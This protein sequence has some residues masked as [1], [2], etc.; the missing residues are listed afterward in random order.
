MKLGIALRRN[1]I[2]GKKEVSP[3]YLSAADNIKAAVNLELKNRNEQFVD[4]RVGMKDYGH[5]K[6]LTL[7][8][9]KMVFKEWIINNTTKVVT[10]TLDHFG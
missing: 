5:I 8:I 2:R 4:I 6:K 3:V 9:D 7:Y 10:K 1:S